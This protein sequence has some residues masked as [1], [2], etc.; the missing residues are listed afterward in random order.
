MY[1]KAF[2]SMFTGSMRKSGPDV[3]AIWV[4]ILSNTDRDHH[5]EINCADIADRI[6]NITAERV[7]QIVQ[8]FCE[9][10][11]ASRSKV[12]EGRKLTREGEYDYFVINHAEYS[13]IL[14]NEDRKEYF[15]RKQNEYRDRKRQKKKASRKGPSPL[16]D[17]AVKAA[18]AGDDVKYDALVATNTFSCATEATPVQP[19]LDNLP[20]PQ[21]TS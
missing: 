3:F 20:R 19:L 8:K 13:K 14:N 15:R 7:G 2:A 4:Y 16:E 18:M 11:E 6:G 5:V 17:A 12:H 21:E 9:P 1:A 10:D